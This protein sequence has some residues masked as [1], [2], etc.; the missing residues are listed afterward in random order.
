ML[1]L[2]GNQ[3]VR[4]QIVDL[5]TYT[6]SRAP[7]AD[8]SACT[9]IFPAQSLTIMADMRLTDEPL[10]RRAGD[11]WT[12]KT[13]RHGRSNGM[14]LALGRDGEVVVDL[15]ES[16]P[17]RTPAHDLFHRLPDPAYPQFDDPELESDIS[18]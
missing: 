16:D 10:R 4:R 14:T 2:S 13:S 17:T 9:Q 6:A 15:V 18:D 7:A 11:Y 8:R 1:L 5:M 12:M 3:V